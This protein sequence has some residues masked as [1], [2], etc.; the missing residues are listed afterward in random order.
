MAKITVQMHIHEEGTDFSIIN[1]TMEPLVA[2]WNYG[3]MEF[4]VYM[5]EDYTNELAAKHGIRKV[6]SSEFSVE[7]L[8]D[9]FEK[10]T[11]GGQ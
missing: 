3:T 9:L 5:L 11:I 6:D 7:V 10:I 2:H 4:G 1:Y 8:W